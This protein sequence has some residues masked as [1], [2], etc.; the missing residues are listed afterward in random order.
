M[1]DKEFE[2]LMV[3]ILGENVFE[4]FKRENVA[5]HLELQRTF[6]NKKRT[7]HSSTDA[8]ITFT[9]PCS[10][11]DTFAEA[12]PGQTVEER[13]AS[14]TRYAN[15]LT[16]KSDKLRIKTDIA[17]DLFTPSVQKVIDH[18]S[19]LLQHPEVENIDALILVGGLS[20]CP[21]LHEDIKH[22][23]PLKRLVIPNQAGLAVLIGAVINGHELEAVTERISRLTYGV[24]AIGQFSPGSHNPELMF[25]DESG[26]TMC[27]G[28]FSVH[29]QAGEAVPVG[30]AGE[31]HQYVV[32]SKHQTKLGIP[33]YK[34]QDQH[35]KYIFEDGCEDIGQLVVD[36]YDTSKGLNR[37][38][39]VVF[40]FGGAEIEVKVSDMHTKKETN[41]YFNFLE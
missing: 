35:P 4:Q 2:K 23:F 21:F 15:N 1:V 13:V 25:I 16:W 41:G 29:V 7:L 19:D 18:V 32:V 40:T 12:N 8:K 20:E 34:T 27:R 24:G 3:D 28:L 39:D 11:L 22:K 30:I 33:I 38:V 9:L 6:E 37:G 31:S 14:H 36:M 26:N 17:K 5:D 10:L